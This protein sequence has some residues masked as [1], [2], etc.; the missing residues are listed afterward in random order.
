[1]GYFYQPVCKLDSSQ[2]RKLKMKHAHS[3][4]NLKKKMIFEQNICFSILHHE[5]NIA[6]EKVRMR[7][8]NQP[9]L[10]LTHVKHNLNHNQL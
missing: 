1:M 7:L 9:T 3:Y 10:F 8:H 2:L 5:Q 4:L 6:Q